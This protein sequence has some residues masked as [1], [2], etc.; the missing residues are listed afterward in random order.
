MTHTSG[1]Q[2]S[3]FEHGSRVQGYA[4]SSAFLPWHTTGGQLSTMFLGAVGVGYAR[5][6]FNQLNPTVGNARSSFLNFSSL[7]PIVGPH[8]GWIV[9]PPNPVP[10]H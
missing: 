5:S 10:H 3:S 4:T 8:A 7:T 2:S 1:F 9:N 6:S